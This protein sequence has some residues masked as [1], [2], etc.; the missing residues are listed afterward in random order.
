MVGIVVVI[1]ILAV[2]AFMFLSPSTSQDALAPTPESQ[3]AEDVQTG[4]PVVD[5]GATTASPA[6]VATAAATQGA[7]IEVTDTGFTPPQVTVAPG[8]KVTFVNNGQA[9]HWPASA[10]H[11]THTALPGFDA[12]KGLATGESYSFTFEKI[13]VWKFHDH[14]NPSIFGAVTVE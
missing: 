5:S 7:T 3:V 1:A 14:L 4:Q 11:P 6:P 13:G 8:T 2:A 10:P 12:K 9:L